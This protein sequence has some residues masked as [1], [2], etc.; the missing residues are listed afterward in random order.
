MIKNSEL[1]KRDLEAIAQFKRV[2]MNY[3]RMEKILEL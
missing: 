2:I 3:L 1:T